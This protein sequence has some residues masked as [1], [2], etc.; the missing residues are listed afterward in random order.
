MYTVYKVAC[1]HFHPLGSLSPAP[2]F[3]RS[4]Q[5]ILSIFLQLIWGKDIRSLLPVTC[6]PVL[7]VGLVIACAPVISSARAVGMNG[8]LQRGVSQ[9]GTCLVGEQ[10][11]ENLCDKGWLH[12]GP[13]WLPNARRW[14][15]VESLLSF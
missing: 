12:A 10:A 5:W 15:E 7:S 1:Q 9:P 6:L 13:M 8:P 14:V 3:S 2:Q 4:N 11:P